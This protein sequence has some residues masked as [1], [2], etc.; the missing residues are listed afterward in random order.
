MAAL[1]IAIVQAEARD[2]VS[3]HLTLVRLNSKNC[4]Q[5]V[6]ADGTTRNVQEIPVDKIRGIKL[7]EWLRY[8]RGLVEG[9]A[10]EGAP[11]IVI[12][13]PVAAAPIGPAGVSPAVAGPIGRCNGSVNSLSDS[14]E[15]LR[16]PIV[17]PD[18]SVHQSG[19][20]DGSRNAARSDLP[21]HPPGS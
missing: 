14:S 21:H 12:N 1:S 10:V 3:K 19:E 2:K 7:E 4:F 8:A 16:P 15:P 13:A 9:K 20:S 17:S 18:I 6:F 5:W 11:P